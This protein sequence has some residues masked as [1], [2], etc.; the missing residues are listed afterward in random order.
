MAGGLDNITGSGHFDVALSASTSGL[1]GQ[2]AEEFSSQ[3][4]VAQGINCP[5]NGQTL[6]LDGSILLVKI[7]LVRNKMGLSWPG[8]PCTSIAPS[9]TPDA[10]TLLI[11]KVWTVTQELGR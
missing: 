4:V 8:S 2:S 11:C 6:F 10:S 9:P 1:G 3:E 5:L 7:F